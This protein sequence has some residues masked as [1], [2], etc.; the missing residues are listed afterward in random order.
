MQFIHCIIISKGPQRNVYACAG[1][2]EFGGGRESAP[3]ALTAAPATN[4]HTTRTP[5]LCDPMS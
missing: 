2:T 3:P 1:Y 4:T 5:N